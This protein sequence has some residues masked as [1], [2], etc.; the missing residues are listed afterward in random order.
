MENKE[1][2]VEDLKQL[3]KIIR[4]VL[5]DRTDIE[6]IPDL[7]FP[8]AREV[9]KYYQPKLPEDSIV[10]SRENYE[11]LLQNKLVTIQT[12]VDEELAEQAYKE[13]VERDN[14]IK[15]AKAIFAKQFGVKIE[16]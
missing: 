6:Y 8:I 3:A 9:L 13:K 10:I 2:Q 16:E 5:V 15:E 1:K 4:T 7:D 14:A 12:K 11:Q